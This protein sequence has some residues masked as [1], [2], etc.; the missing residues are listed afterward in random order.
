MAI[1][2]TLL[3]GCQQE[4]R[5]IL[6]PDEK[7]VIS[8]DTWDYYQTY[9]QTISGG[10]RG[11]FVVSED[12]YYA[13]YTYCRTVQGCYFHINYSGEALKDCVSDGHKCVV[14]AKDDE[15]VVPYEVAN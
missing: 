15:I 7:F 2:A 6:Q 1:S 8:S 4:G 11:A 13:T 5:T 3:S 10:K 9:L 12:G 14:F